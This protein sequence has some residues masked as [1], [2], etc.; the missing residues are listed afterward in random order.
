MAAA[1]VAVAGPGTGRLLLFSDLRR[2]CR[3]FAHDQQHCVLVL[4]AVLGK[5]SERSCS[6]ENTLALCRVLLSSDHQQERE[7][8]S[9]II[10]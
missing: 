5:N 4:G 6:M 1:N 3:T 2:G 7:E 9:C 10:E 8:I